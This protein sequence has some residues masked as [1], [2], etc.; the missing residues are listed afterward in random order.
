[1]SDDRRKVWAAVL[2]PESLPSDWMSVLENT[3]VPI[4]VSPLHDR[5][6][7]TIE[8][9]Q[10]NP[11]HVAG[12]RKKPHYHV[13]IYFDSL[14]SKNQVLTLIE[15]LGVRYVEPVEAPRAYNRYLCHLD[16][17]GKAQYEPDEIIRLNGAQCD[18]SEPNPT[19]DEQRKIQSDVIALIRDINMTEYAELVDY[20]YDN[21][22]KDWAWYVTHNTVFL[23]NYIKSRRHGYG[24]K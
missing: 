16:Q 8:D 18:I 19:Q 3:R 21:G 15:P 7:W 13:V 22:L 5:D 1:M 6:V 14:K 12:E 17:R 20:V 24:G 23:N 11:N 9:Q 2:Y 10:S 4:A